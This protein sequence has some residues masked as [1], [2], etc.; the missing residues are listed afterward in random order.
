MKNCEIIDVE[1]LEF[2]KSLTDCGKALGTTPQNIWNCIAGG[3][4]VKGRNLIYFKEWLEWE[5]WVKEIYTK[6]MGVYWL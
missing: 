1:N 5:S 3:Y 2:W 6:R 4:R